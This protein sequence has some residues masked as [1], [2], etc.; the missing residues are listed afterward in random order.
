[1]SLGTI[2]YVGN[3]ELPD[4]NAAAHRVVNNAKIFREL[5]YRVA[6]LGTVRGESF[7]GYKRTPESSVASRQSPEGGDFLLL[8]KFRSFFFHQFLPV[9][10]CF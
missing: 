3:F 9:L 2:L 7:S 8:C 6:L 10:F 5:G 4:K 1:M